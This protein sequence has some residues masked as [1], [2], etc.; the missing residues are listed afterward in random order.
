MFGFLQAL[1]NGSV[2]HHLTWDILIV[3]VLIGGALLYS[4]LIGRK[5]IVTMLVSVYIAL[6]VT[7]F[8]PFTD[9][10]AGLT[11][12][13]AFLIRISVFI[14][15]TLITS[16]LFVRSKFRYL[17]DH[18]ERT[19]F[20]SAYLMS[21]VQVGLFI[22]IILFLLPVE[23]TQNLRVWTQFLFTNPTA[24][25]VWMTLPILSLAVQRK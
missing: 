22:A 18:H 20:M 8:F 3:S 6:A 24:R 14:G 10:L 19:N 4:I 2:A 17:L 23:F 13:D 9:V 25:F 7:L 5:Q 12:I 1:T 16:L 15:V 21:L 11:S